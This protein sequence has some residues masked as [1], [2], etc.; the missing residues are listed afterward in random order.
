MRERTVVVHE[1]YYPPLGEWVENRVFPTLDGGLAIFQRYVTE[2]KKAQEAIQR[3]EAR[4]AEAQRL[5]HMGSGVWNVAT[6][7][8]CWSQ[9]AY[10]IYGFDP[11]AMTP[12]ADLFFQLVH[13]EDRARLEQAFS[14]VM[15]QRRDYEL[16]FRIVRPDGTTRHIHSVGHPVFS[17]SGEVT[18]VVG[19]VLDITERRQA[20]EERTQLLRRLMTAHEEERR[21][22]SRELHDQFGQQLT[23][24]SL[25]LATLKNDYCADV[26]LCDQIES[27]EVL[28]RQLDADV[29][30]IVWNLRPTALDDLGLSVALSDFVTN[31]SKRFGIHAELHTGEINRDELAGD[32]ETVLYRVLQEAL[33]NIAKHASAKNVAILLERHPDHVSLIV[34]DDGRG[35]DSDRVLG[36][37]EKGLGLVGM[38]ERALLVGGTLGIESHPGDGTTVVVRIPVADRMMR[39]DRG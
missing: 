31:W 35:F 23:A 14:T 16:D 10:R 3:S 13:P 20:E 26:A 2:R 22:L 9:E 11:S 12:S 18:E 38:R 4:L 24:L 7:E 28:A 17:D 19:T 21:R 29:G 34:E 25:K 8:V 6:G 1:H 37:D 32:A 36:A 15:Q 5:T 27:L 33:T 39:A 30:S